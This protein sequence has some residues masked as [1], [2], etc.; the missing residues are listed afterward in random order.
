MGDF[1]GDGRPDVAA[2][3][4][5]NGALGI[6]LGN[7]DGS[8]RTMPLLQVGP[9]S[10]AMVAGDFNRDGRLDLAVGGTDRLSILINDGQW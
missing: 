8:F 6:L 3:D 2:L 4:T 7:G 10:G 1:D 5:A 9:G